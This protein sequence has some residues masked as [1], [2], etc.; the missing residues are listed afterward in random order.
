MKAYTYSEASPFDV[1][2]V[3]VAVRSPEWVDVVR[4]GRERS[5]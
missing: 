4:A 5:T 3:E 2:G 1:K